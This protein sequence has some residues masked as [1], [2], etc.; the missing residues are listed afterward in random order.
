[1]SSELEGRKNLVR[2]L[3]NERVFPVPGEPRTVGLA[4]VGN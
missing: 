3:T 4:V 2:G 1:M